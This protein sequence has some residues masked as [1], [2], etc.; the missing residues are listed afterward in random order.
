MLSLP[1]V[2][3]TAIEPRCRILR[4]QTR[5]DAELLKEALEVAIELIQ[6]VVHVDDI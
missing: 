5:Y 2:P 4:V 6:E 1:Y 3:C